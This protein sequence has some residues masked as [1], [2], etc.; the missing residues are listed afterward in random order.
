LSI[1][2]YF[3]G[4]AHTWSNVNL[5]LDGLKIGK[6]KFGAILN[7]N[8]YTQQLDSAQYSVIYDLHCAEAVFT[9][10]SQ[11]TGFEPGTTYQFFIRLKALPFNSGFGAGNRG[12]P[13]GTGTGS[14]Y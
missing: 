4:I 9:V 3:D 2:S 14:S 12:Q 7:Y 13:L 1:G 5:F 10:M 6:T 8:G 11:N